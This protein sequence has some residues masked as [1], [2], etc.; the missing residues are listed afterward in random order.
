MSRIACLLVIDLPVAAAC[1]ADPD[2]IGLPLALTEG[3]GPRDLIVAAAPAARARGVRP[4]R[5][6]VVQARAVTA[7]LVVRQ[8]NRAAERSAIGALAD[9][10]ASLASRI[11]IEA[12]GAVLL[13]VTGTKHL[14][15]TEAGLATALVTRA[16]RVGLAARAGIASTMTTAKLAALHGTGTEVVPAA[17][18]LGFLAPLPITCLHPSPALARVL[19]QWGL[20]RLGDL[21][22]LPAAEVGTRLGAEGAALVR[23]ARGCDER[24]L[25]PTQRSDEIEESLLLD[26]PIDTVEPLVFVLRGLLARVTDRLGLAGI[27]CTR[28]GLTCRLDDRSRDE[29]A[30]RLAAPTRDPKTMLTLLRLDVEARPPRAAIDEVALTVTPEVIRPTQL[31]LFTPAGPAP[32]QLATTLARLGVLCGT[33]RVGAPVVVDTHRPGVAAVA[34]F[35]PT[36]TAA[37]VAARCRVVVRAVRPPQRLEVFSERDRPAFVRGPDLG[38]RVVEIAGPWRIAAEWWTASPCRRDYY[39]LELSDGGLYRCYR[40]LRS[41]RWFVDGVY[42]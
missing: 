4:G 35:E 13:D 22:R 30:L 14:V 37:A 21:A 12:D 26:H 29:R 6:S 39:D 34:P 9:V 5:H 24:P 23:R 8:R 38:G 2:L 7:E 25:L 18:E 32:E 33:E 11:E 19:G 27:G 15:D 40:E 10:A 20:H 42:D 3:D 17:I 16:E 36:D 41:G 1:R 28:L 31:G